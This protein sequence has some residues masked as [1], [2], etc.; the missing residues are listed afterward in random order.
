MPDVTYYNSSLTGEQIEN[1]LTHPVLTSVQS[2]TNAQKEQARTNIGAYN[3]PSG[4]IPTTDLSL[5]VMG[6]L[7][8][9]GGSTGQVLKKHSNTSYDV[10]WANE[11]GGGGAVASVNGQTGVVVLDAEDVGALPSSTTIPTKTSDLTNDSG[12]LTS[13]VT[14]F[15]GNTGAVTYSAPVASVDGKTGTVVVLPTG[16]TTGQ[17]LKK[18]SNADYAVAWGDGGG[19]GGGGTSDYTDLSNK[20][21]INGNTLSGNKTSSDL[22]LYPARPDGIAYADMASGVKASLD[23]ADTALQTAPVVSVD[24]KTGAVNVL[25]SGGSAGQV[26]KKSSA[27]NYAVEWAAESGGVPTPA[28][29]D[30]GKV[31]TATSGGGFF[32]N[33]VPSELPS[34]GQSG[35]YLKKTGSAAYDT[36]WATVREVP[37]STTSDNGKVLKVVSGSAEWANESELPSVTTSDNGKVLTVVSGAWAAETS[38][39][40]GASV[41]TYS[42]YTVPTGSWQSIG[43]TTGVYYYAFEISGVTTTMTYKT[44]VDLTLDY[45]ALTYLIGEG[46]QAAYIENYLAATTGRY[47]RIVIVT[48]GS[49]APSSSFSIGFSYYETV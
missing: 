16:G 19:G 32:W 9:N 31:L 48:S 21:Q 25:P 1:V 34:G 23:K 43:G 14:S 28:S 42:S 13:A 41:K 10:E 8:P 17:V 44:K 15:N 7:L 35:Q 5:T 47:L 26:L 24:G 36:D 22:G 3:K 38:S 33:A 18:S 2:L 49:S 45:A 37:S 40:G 20:P 11:S 39:G 4:G 30:S 29:A 46:V 6:Q 27:D 12:F